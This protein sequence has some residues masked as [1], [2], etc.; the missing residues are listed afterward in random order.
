MYLCLD[1][2]LRVYMHVCAAS[3]FYVG[4]CVAI[5]YDILREIESEMFCEL[6]YG[7]LM[8]NSNMNSNMTSC[9]KSIMILGLARS[10]VA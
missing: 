5:A 1:V 10:S 7:N 2:F 4:T 9:V 6:E 3:L 8:R